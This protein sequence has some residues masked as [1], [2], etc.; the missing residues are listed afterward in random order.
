MVAEALEATLL[1]EYNFPRSAFEGLRLR[2]LVAEQPVLS[3]AEVALEATTAK[4]GP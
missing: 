3:M 1:K 4:I 2:S